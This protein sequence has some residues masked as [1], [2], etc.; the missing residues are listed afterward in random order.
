[1]KKK[2]VVVLIGAGLIGLAIARRISVGKHLVIADY[3]QKNIDNVRELLENSGYETSGMVTDIS[4]KESIKNLVKFAQEKG[5]VKN[6][7]QAAG[8]SPSQ[9][10]IQRILEVDL[11]G[12]AVILE[13][14]GNIIK[15]GGSGVVISSQS[16]HRLPALTEKEDRE[17]ATASVDELLNLDVVKNI[18]DTLHAYQISKRGNSLRVKAEANHWTERGARINTIS[19]GIIMTPLAKDELT[20]ER[21]EFYQNMLA[22][23][24]AGRVGIADEIAEL[25]DLLMSDRGSFITGS[26]FLIDGG[27]TASYFYGKLQPKK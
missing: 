24:P 27:A 25:A 18:K 4:S 7:I 20:G 14:F 6:L 5:E 16:G 19:P 3:S 21:A 23:I 9:A 15:E 10:S 26:D 22:N 13:E 8:V 17:L 2:E 12:T 1:M 11:Y